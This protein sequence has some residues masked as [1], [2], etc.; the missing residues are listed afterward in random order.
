MTTTPTGYIDNNTKR[1]NDNNTNRL[2]GQ[3]YQ[4][5]ILTAIPIGYNT[6]NTN[7]IS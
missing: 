5:V 1:F 3:Q 2:L 6:K 7:D 4:Q